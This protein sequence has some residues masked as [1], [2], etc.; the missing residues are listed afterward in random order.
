MRGLVVSFRIVGWGIIC[1]RG[2]VPVI[3]RY[4]NVLCPISA[5][6]PCD[7]NAVKRL[8]GLRLSW[9]ALRQA[10]TRRETGA[11]GIRTMIT[12]GVDSIDF[13]G[14]RVGWIAPAEG[15]LN[16]RTISGPPDVYQPSCRIRGSLEIYYLWRLLCAVGRLWSAKCSALRHLM[17]NAQSRHFIS[18]RESK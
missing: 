4:L 14:S 10:L 7:W 12:Y 3:I 8:A 16:F 11:Q 15:T 6:S 13:T 1:G 2:W 17:L 5:T 18:V 9:Q